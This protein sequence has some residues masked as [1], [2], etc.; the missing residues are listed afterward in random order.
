M[1]QIIKAV[2][3]V[4]A[5]SQRIKNKNIK[6]FADSNLLE[7]KINQ[8]KKITKLD[9]IIVN[10]DSDEMLNVA[11]NLG[12]EV[13]KRDA[14]YASSEVSINEVYVN[15]AEHCDS[16]I[17]LFADVTNPLI[18]DKTI[19]DVVNFYFD[20]KNKYDSVNTVNLIKMFLWQN[21]TPLN[22]SEKNKPRSQDLPDIYAIN[23]AIN[24]LSKET[25]I[26]CKA[27]VGEK[28]YLYPVDNIEGL[29]IDNEIDFEFA[30]FM[31]KKYRMN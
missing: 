9:G 17:I 20:N 26:K 4:R 24:V 23:S 10:S 6:P 5:S 12:V 29:D 19:E 14:Y 21:G 8:L 7:I 3:P 18:K 31:Y 25:M 27:F 22:Y 30:E 13:V 2:I 28:P 15:L 16:D 11:K 1:K